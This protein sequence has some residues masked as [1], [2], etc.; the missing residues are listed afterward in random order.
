MLLI[1]RLLTKVLLSS[2]SHLKLCCGRAVSWLLS[3]YLL[4]PA[5]SAFPSK[6]IPPSLSKHSKLD[7]HFYPTFPAFF[8]TMSSYK[9]ATPHL[10]SSSC[11]TGCLEVEQHASFRHC[12]PPSPLVVRNIFDSQ[13]PILHLSQLGF[14]NLGLLNFIG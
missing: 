3:S 4:A 5:R 7:Q 12:S 13:P 6:S 1:E 9:F 11:S 2:C 8:K 14:S 10:S